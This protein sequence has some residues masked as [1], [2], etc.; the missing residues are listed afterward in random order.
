MRLPSWRL[1]RPRRR[2]SPLYA[3]LVA[4]GLLLLWGTLARVL[5]LREVPHWELRHLIH[6]GIGSG[7][8][9]MSACVVALA[10]YALALLH[11]LAGRGAGTLAVAAVALFNFVDYHY[12]LN[13]G[14]HLPFSSLEYLG[15]AEH[16]TSS[17]E[18]VLLHPTFPGMLLAPVALAAWLLLASAGAAPAASGRG[19]WRRHALA[20][21]ALF[22]AGLAG[23]TVSNSYV[24]KNLENPLQF[25]PLQYFLFTADR[26][27]P[28]RAVL[29]AD[30]K[31]RWPA[32]DLAYPFWKP[33][34]FAGCGTAA[35]AFR[36]FCAGIARLPQPPN[37]VFVMLES[38]R[39]AEL[40]AYGGDPADS[41]NFDR[42]ASG[43]LL[44]RDFY[45]NSYQTRHGII[46]AYCSMYPNDGLSVLRSYP[47]VR[48]RCLP[49]VLRERGY[50]TLWVHNGDAEFDGM[51]RFLLR[52]GVQ[53]VY[54]RWDFPIGTETLGWGLSDVAL[55]E[56]T[57]QELA[58]TPQPF[59][60]GLLSMTNHHPF[61]VPPAFRTHSGEGEYGLYRNGMAYTDHALGR[62]FELARTQPFF[63][64]TVFFIF[65]DHSTHYDVPGV[66]AGSP[67]ALT[68]QFH[69]PLLI[70]PGW[71]L[72]GRT[73]EL[74]ASQI[75]L[76]PTALD[77]LGYS[78][79]LPWVG[80]SLLAPAFRSLAL[81]HK[82]ANFQV[83]IHPDGVGVT[84]GGQLTWHPSHLGAAPPRAA[85]QATHDALLLT[86]WV[87]QHDHVV[88]RHDT[89]L[90]AGCP[91]TAPA[92]PHRKD[93]ASRTTAGLCR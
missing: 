13:F 84:R 12:V 43:G 47:E 29:S 9:L 67:R 80:A 71:P 82:P 30:L 44:V 77:L 1:L 92:A 38:F 73:L 45:G 54:D 28:Q 55:M 3:A 35:A 53:R 26:A 86:N 91:K 89:P 36:E 59:F 24:A 23:N 8:E 10:V 66:E 22:L 79:D 68:E 5:V 52:N 18:G 90:A 4:G 87:L 49:E 33:Q 20:L 69:I 48:L 85:L 42:L 51:R 72:K 21:G 27:G 15:D 56:K 41:P 57:V 64:N 7:Y 17:I 40:G 58:H 11:P 76:A 88:P 2:R 6:F 81:V 31:A 61:E 34:T 19:T 62:L 32:P 14:T 70:V 83:L 37:I 16:F 39:A 63:A 60:A 78:G 65:G 93:D 50:S 46:S 74:I 75:D 25:T